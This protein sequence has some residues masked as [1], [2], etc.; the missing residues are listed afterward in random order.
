MNKL[1]PAV[2]TLAAAAWGAAPGARTPVGA[3]RFYP[4]KPRDLQ[5]LVDRQLAGAMGQR[6]PDGARVV[7]LLVPHSG[8]EYSG[9]LAARAFALVKKGDFDEVIVAATSHY[10]EMEGAALYPG[11]YGTP[12]GSMPYD[13]EL[14]RRLTAASPLIKLDAAAHAKEHS[15]EV[16]IPFLRRALGPVPLVGLLMNTQ[17]LETARRVGAAI[18]KAAAGRRVLLVASSDQAHF[19]S[20]GVAEAVDGTTLLA[21]QTLDPAYFWLTNRLL[22]NRG[23]PSLAVTYCGEGAVMAVLQAARA[24]GADRERVLGRI[25]SG[26]VVA[27]RDY[28]HVVGYAAVA[29]TREAGAAPAFPRLSAAQKKRLLSAARQALAAGDKTAAVPLS[30]DPVFNLPAAVALT[31][32]DAGGAERGKA[33][34]GQAE[35][36]LLEAVVSAA[37]R[38][39]AAAGDPA[40]LKIA[41][42][43]VSPVPGDRQQAFSE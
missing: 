13:A 40:K 21:L 10:K 16:E 14:A 43:V 34:A 42:S 18:A 38:A 29:F 23:V 37:A 17:D 4:A 30:S 26:D 27:E 24:A 3:G 25:N 9:A 19:P 35:E 39:G 1:L 33:A 5:A 28:N 20:G 8:L 22:L 31:L 12:G 6:L 36:S 32:T 2:L 7:A 11:S 41:V 15:I